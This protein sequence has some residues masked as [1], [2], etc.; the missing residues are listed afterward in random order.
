MYVCMSVFS[1]TNSPCNNMTEDCATDPNNG[2]AIC[3]CK[4]G[5]GRDN[6]TVSCTG[7]RVDMMR[8]LNKS[9]I[10]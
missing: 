9:W 8:E 6:V 1:A 7:M 2:S 4:L 3:S 5:Y 10:D